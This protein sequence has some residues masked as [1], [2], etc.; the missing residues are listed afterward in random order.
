MLVVIKDGKEKMSGMMSG[1]KLELLGFPVKMSDI[2]SDI[3][4][5]VIFKELEKI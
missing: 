3:I 5:K 1:M 2:M 4:E